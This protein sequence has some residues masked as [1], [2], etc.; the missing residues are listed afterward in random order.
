[1]AIVTSLATIVGAVMLMI[2][3][4][5]PL[6]DLGGGSLDIPLRMARDLI[7]GNG[8]YILET[9][10]FVVIW[11]YLAELC[12]LVPALLGGGLIGLAMHQL[13]KYQRLNLR[14]TLGVGS[15]VGLLAGLITNA[16]IIPRVSGGGDGWIG[17]YPGSPIW[18]AVIGGAWGVFQSLVMGIWLEMKTQ[19]RTLARPRVRSETGVSVLEAGSWVVRSQRVD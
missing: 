16:Y 9:L 19:V 12:A 6:S 1:M 11:L 7:T 10:M 18:A 15:L 4:Y 13:T 14:S 17:I 2:F 8:M 5:I 3:V